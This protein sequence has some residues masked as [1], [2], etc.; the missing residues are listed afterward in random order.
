MPIV[1]VEVVGPAANAGGGAVS[2]RALA[3]AL[4]QVFGCPAGRTWVRL[5]R[6][7]DAAYAENGAVLGESEWPVFVTVQHARLPDEAALRAEAA[8]VTLAVAR[9]VGRPPGRVHVHYAPAGAGRLAFGGQ[10]VG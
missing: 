1:D 2:A 7:D 4:G 3:D 9:C 6:L 10:L 5:R 8:A